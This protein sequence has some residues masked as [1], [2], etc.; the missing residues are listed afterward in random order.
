MYCT[1]LY[2]NFSVYFP[3]IEVHFFTDATHDMQRSAC[4]LYLLPRSCGVVHLFTFQL[5]CT[6][7]DLDLVCC[8]VGW[9][10]GVSIAWQASVYLL[11]LLLF[12]CGVCYCY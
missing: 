11:C 10:N 12:F 6:G 8:L 4:L 3:F 2:F 7:T 1:V 5:V 9:F